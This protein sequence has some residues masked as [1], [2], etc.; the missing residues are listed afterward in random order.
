MEDHEIFLER[1]QKS[2]PARWQMAQWFA[3]QGY[4]VVVNPLWYAATADQWRGNSDMGDLYVQTRMEVKHLRCEFTSRQDWP[5]G[6]D[7]IVC[8]RNSYDRAKPKPHAYWLLNHSRTHVARV[9]TSSFPRW[10][11]AKRRDYGF[12]NVEQEYYF[13]PLD[14]VRF[15]RLEDE[16]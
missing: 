13:A 7:F 14:D 4:V 3:K 6:K 2:E 10:R 12:E 1:L 15:S 5:H 9:L 8:S 16:T 11:V